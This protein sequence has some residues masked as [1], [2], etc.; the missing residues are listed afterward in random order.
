MLKD[1][2]SC[3]ISIFFNEVYVKKF[4]Y[5]FFKVYIINADCDGIYFCYFSVI[6]FINR[7]VEW[8]FF[9]IFY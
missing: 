3:F 4:C 1:S 2:C 8:K 7:E 5:Y 6:I 9:Y